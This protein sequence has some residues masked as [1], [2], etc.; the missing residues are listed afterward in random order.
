MAGSM[1]KQLVALS[2]VVFSS[3]MLF[4]TTAYAHLPSWGKPGEENRLDNIAVSVAYYQEL[5]APD[6]IDLFTFTATAG[7]HLHVGISIPA[8]SGLEDYD[9]SLALLGPGLPPEGIGSLPA[10]HA[11]APGAVIYPAAQGEDFFEPFTQP[12]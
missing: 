3:S 12:S 6:Q 4:T 10:G 8:V 9:V 7:E 1:I 11:D 2:A 5:I